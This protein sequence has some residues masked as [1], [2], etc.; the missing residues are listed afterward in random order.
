V[1]A[2]HWRTPLHTGT[3]RS[4][5]AKVRLFRFDDRL[6][7][8]SPGKLPPPITLEQLGYDQFSRNRLIARVLVE[9]GYIE[10]V[11][12][13]IRRLREEMA[14]L[15]LPEPEFRGDGFSFVITFRGVAP[16][17]ATPMPTRSVHGWS[18]ARSTKDSRGGCCT[19]KDTG[20]S[21]V[22]STWR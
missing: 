20:P 14:S 3:G 4:K 12:P 16:R 22:V 10:E 21:P 15:E 6:E 2:G 5:G 11:G 7:I 13:G 9:Q 18:G 8:W 19:R 17:G 1:S